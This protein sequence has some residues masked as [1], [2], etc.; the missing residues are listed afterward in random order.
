MSVWCVWGLGGYLQTLQTFIKL[1]MQA[2]M[3]ESV[4]AKQTKQTYYQ[5]HKIVCRQVEWIYELFRHAEHVHRCWFTAKCH[6][7]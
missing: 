7:S 5:R 3:K 4:Q 6:Y 2:C 1:L